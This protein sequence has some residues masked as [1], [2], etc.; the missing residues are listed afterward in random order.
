MNDND[1]L[2]SLR[3]AVERAPDDAALRLHL[4]RYL[5]DSGLRSEAL[6]EVARALAD[7][8]ESA[9][10]RALMTAALGP[11]VPPRA[12]SE[13]SAALEVGDFDWDQ[14]AVDLGDVLPPLFVD[15][16]GSDTPAESWEIERVAINLGDVGGL[17]DVKQRLEASFLGPLRNPELRRLYCKSL[18]GGLLLYGPPGCGKSYL[19]RALAGELDAGLVS[20]SIH[21][22]LDMWI[23][24]S[25]RNLHGIFEL[26]RRNAPCVLFIDELDALGIARSSGRS[27]RRAYATPRRKTPLTRES[28]RA[29]SVT[30]ATTSRHG[31]L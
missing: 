17:D 1:L 11:E 30:A 15:G 31:A 26:A 29:Y 19:A 5:L 9:V 8:P 14:A 3:A 24:A 7:D 23:G 16:E 21:D 12:A 18:G 28:L 10:G 6:Q 13:S 27:W 25:E 2:L 22:V 20:V 4:A